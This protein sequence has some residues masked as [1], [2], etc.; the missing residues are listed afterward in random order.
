[1]R[2]EERPTRHVDHS[3]VALGIADVGQANA[4]VAGGAFYNGAAWLQETCGS[5]GGGGGE[6]DGRK[7]ALPQAA[8]T[9]LLS[10]FD[11]I[12]GSTVLDGAARVHKLGLAQDVAA[13]G[14]GDMLEADEGGAAGR[15]EAT[16]EWG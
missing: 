8:P 16:S 11:E 6:F 1:M 4:R 9:S 13:G 14:L 7:S 10:V 12:E 15:A 3:L 5:G 2:D